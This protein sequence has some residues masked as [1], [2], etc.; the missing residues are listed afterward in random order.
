[1]SDTYFDDLETRSTD[2]RATAQAALLNER[3][4]S[5]TDAPD[6]WRAAGFQIIKIGV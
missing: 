2:A 5:I 4:V 3:L 6:D 1:M